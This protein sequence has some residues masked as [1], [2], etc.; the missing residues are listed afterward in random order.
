MLLFT[1]SLGGYAQQKSERNRSNPERREGDNRGPKQEDERGERTKGEYNHQHAHGENGERPQHGNRGDS[2]L[3]RDFMATLNIEHQ[4]MRELSMAYRNYSEEL[5]SIKEKS[6][7]QEPVD[8]AQLHQ[9]NQKCKAEHFAEVQKLLTDSAYIS[10]CHYLNMGE[11][12]KKAFDTSLKLKLSPDQ[13]RH[14]DAIQKSVTDMNTKLM[15]QYGGDRTMLSLLQ[16]AVTTRQKQMLA[17][18]LSDEQ[19]AVYNEANPERRRRH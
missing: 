19:M 3:S 11:E 17:T 5:T 4:Q 16:K 15:M 12:E 2:G 7:E 8:R 18:I 9:L 6:S 13:K 14:Y 10:Y 1:I